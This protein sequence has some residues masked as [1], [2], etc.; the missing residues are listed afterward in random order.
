MTNAD[1]NTPSAKTGTAGKKAKS[2]AQATRGRSTNSKSSNGN[3]TTSDSGTKAGKGRSGRSSNSRGNA[4]SAA[5]L[6]TTTVASLVGAGIAVGIGMIASRTLQARREALVHDD[7]VD[8]W[9]DDYVAN[10]DFDGDAQSMEAYSF[11]NASA[12]PS[13]LSVTGAQ[14][15]GEVKG[16]NDVPS[17]VTSYSGV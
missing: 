14:T 8:N 12:E 2:T 1:S 3:T 5:P 16:G 10:T 15:T 7:E 13:R 6:L 17:A 9:N 11:D 4:S